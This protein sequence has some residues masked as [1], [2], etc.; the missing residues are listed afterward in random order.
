MI[1]LTVWQLYVNEEWFDR[2]NDFKIKRELMWVILVFS[3]A[4][5]EYH[6]LIKKYIIRNIQ[7]IVGNVKA[8]SKLECDVNWSSGNPT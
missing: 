7:C 8:C 3:L 4:C 6:V 2:N 1:A 5:E